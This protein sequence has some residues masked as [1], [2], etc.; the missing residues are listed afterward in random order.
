[1]IAPLDIDA[2]HCPWRGV[3]YNSTRIIC[4]VLIP[5]FARERTLVSYY[6]R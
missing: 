5:V 2:F 6:P 4:G 3:L 1:M